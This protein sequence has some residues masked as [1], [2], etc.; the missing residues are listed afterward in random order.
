MAKEKKKKRYPKESGSAESEGVD[1]EEQLPHQKGKCD[2]L[3]EASPEEESALRLSEEE[4]RSPVES[5]TKEETS[6]VDALKS[7]VENPITEVQ[8]HLENNPDLNS[9]SNLVIEI[10]S[11]GPEQSLPLEEL[12]KDDLLR[13][14]EVLQKENARFQSVLIQSQDALS[15]LQKKQLGWKEKAIAVTQKD[16]QRI[17][18]L[19]NE[20]V[21]LEAKSAEVT[22]SL[23]EQLQAGN[24]HRDELISQLA[25]KESYFELLLASRLKEECDGLQ[26][27]VTTASDEALAWKTEAESKEEEIAVLKENFKFLEKKSAAITADRKEGQASIKGLEAKVVALE[28]VIEGLNHRF[29][30]MTE[31][32]EKLVVAGAEK[33]KTVGELK[34]KLVAQQERK[35]EEVSLQI[36]AA[37]KKRASLQTQIGVLQEN[38][39]KL[40]NT[41]KEMTN[42]RR[43]LKED[44]ETAREQLKTLEKDRDEQKE[45]QQKVEEELNTEREITKEKNEKLVELQEKTKTWKEKVLARGHAEAQK[46]S[47]LGDVIQLLSA[48]LIQLHS[49]FQELEKKSAIERTFL[50]FAEHAASRVEPMM[51][52]QSLFHGPPVNVGSLV[53]A[54]QTVRTS[55]PASETDGKK[56]ATDSNDLSACLSCVVECGKEIL[57]KCVGA[58]QVG[59][60]AKLQLTECERRLQ[61][62]QRRRNELEKN[63][64][65]TQSIVE[66]KNENFQKVLEELESVKLASSTMKAK[67]EM[68]SSQRT[69]D[70]LLEAAIKWQGKEEELQQALEGTEVKYKA[71]IQQLDSRCQLLQKEIRQLKKASDRFLSSGSSPALH[72]VGEDS[73]HVVTHES[74]LDSKKYASEITPSTN[75]EK[76]SHLSS[77]TVGTEKFSGEREARERRQEFREG[78]TTF[79]SRNSSIGGSGLER[80]SERGQSGGRGEEPSQT[81]H[82]Y[83]K[84]IIFQ[85]LSSS[86]VLRVKMIPA[87][88]TVLGFNSIEK[89][90]I[91]SANPSCPPLR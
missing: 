91:T 40:Q 16:R 44:L 79:P 33:D 65:T 27:A 1:A 22:Q 6:T 71:Q 78:S 14:V 90:A 28:E 80:E 36:S 75:S 73:H 58:I 54:S 59:S 4:N 82:F 77:P 45:Q 89:R 31:E 26:K 32:K 8:D 43:T 37:E 56:N 7:H 23:E 57:E 49:Q 84:N 87:I 39:K 66:E 9:T 86:D 51:I 35:K 20:L 88:V 3:E 24:T 68:E 30:E 17:K 12:T 61:V 83:M 70:A 63:Q 67:Y 81:S 46:M 52:F 53:Q 11:L 19:E 62:E 48:A 41:V 38:E 72:G 25:A 10:T 29:V 55:T 18:E 50:P 47:V 60:D 5:V 74:F 76:L 2:P 85:Y 21:D 69:S 64:L 13:Q 34:E 15:D 42:E